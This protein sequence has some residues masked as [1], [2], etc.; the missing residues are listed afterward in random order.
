MIFNRTTQHSGHAGKSGSHFPLLL[1]LIALV[2]VGCGDDTP[3]RKAYVDPDAKEVRNEPLDLRVTVDDEVAIPAADSATGSDRRRMTAPDGEPAPYS[4]ESLKIVFAVKGDY[5]GTIEHWVDDWGRNEWRR[6]S[7]RD[8]SGELL[9]N[10]LAITTPSESGRLIVDEKIGWKAPNRLMAMYKSEFESREKSPFTM[11]MEQVG[12]EYIGDTT[13][14]GYKT[15]IYRIDGGTTVQTLW[16]WRDFPIRIHYFMPYDDIEYRFEPVSIEHD[17]T[18]PADLFEWPED[19][20]I[21]NLPKP[22]NVN[23]APPPPPGSPI[24]E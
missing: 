7:I 14:A 13:I 10:E 19:Y 17:P 5:S 9:V 4:V 3:E 15:R 8:Q 6:D 24:V 11:T 1:T 16:V 12:G 23:V 22:P 2:L 21:D 20:E 18:I